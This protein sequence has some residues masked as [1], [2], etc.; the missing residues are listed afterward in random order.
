LTPEEF[1]QITLHPL[2]S[3]EILSHVRAFSHLAA[4]AS[5]HHERLDGKGYPWGLGGSDLDLST[6]IITVADVVEAI[7]ANRAHVQ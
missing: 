5:R 6:R 3:W 4:P 1:Q 7:T 2:Y